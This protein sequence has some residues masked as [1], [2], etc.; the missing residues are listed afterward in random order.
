MKTGT[1]KFYN[2]AKGYGFI[3]DETTKEDFFVH[4][5]GLNG[6][7]IQQNDRVEFETQEGRKGINAVNVRKI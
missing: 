6:L 4:V 2:E 3:T 7:D 1:V 5:T